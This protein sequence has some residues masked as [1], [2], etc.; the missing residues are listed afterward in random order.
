MAWSDDML[1][2]DDHLNFE[3]MLEDSTVTSPK[4]T[5]SASDFTCSSAQTTE[6]AQSPSFRLG[7]SNDLLPFIP[8]HR[9]DHAGQQNHQ[10]SISIPS[11]TGITSDAQGLILTPTSQVDPTYSRMAPARRRTIPETPQQNFSK[12]D[13][14][15]VLACT[16]ILVTLENY[17][18]SELRALDLILATVSK[19]VDDLKKLVELQQQSRCDRCII[20]FTTVMLQVIALLEAGSNSAT[21]HELDAVDDIIYGTQPR[22]GP[23]LHF[24][25]FLPTSEEQRSW[26]S[27]II[28]REYR[29]VGEILS[30]VMVLARLGP[31]GS[32]T[33]PTAVDSRLKC[34]GNIEQR[35]KE[36]AA[37]EGSGEIRNA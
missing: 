18:F 37:K 24:G 6:H 21:D 23:S 27:R 26:R 2:L 1:N 30:G 12:L 29:H 20:L 22:P 8:D 11:P 34:L 17:L 9:T 16:Q 33:D 36:M 14:R 7:V 5:S 28:T 25:A 13:S 19:A 3:D 15:C 4:N 35:L 10:D 31:R 32:S